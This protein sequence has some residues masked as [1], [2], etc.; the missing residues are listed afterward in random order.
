MDAENG[1]ELTKNSVL[2]PLKIKLENVDTEKRR[3]NSETKTI[4]YS[5]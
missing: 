3:E 2:W 1:R 4:L 5:P